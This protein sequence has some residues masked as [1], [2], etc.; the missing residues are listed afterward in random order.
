VEEGR[1]CSRGSNPSSRSSPTA[2]EAAPMSGRPT[3]EARLL[4]PLLLFPSI[5]QGSA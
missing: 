5:L 1:E 4:R 2:A 3:T